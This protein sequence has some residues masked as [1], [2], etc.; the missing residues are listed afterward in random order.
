MA[1]PVPAP[2]Q[3]EGCIADDILQIENPKG[4]H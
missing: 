3:A 4:L 1:C 2:N